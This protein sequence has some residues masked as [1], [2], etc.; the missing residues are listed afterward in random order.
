MN[1]LLVEQQRFLEMAEMAPLFFVN[2][3]FLVSFFVEGTC[4]ISRCSLLH[5]DLNCFSFTK[6]LEPLLLV[7][8]GLQRSKKQMVE[9]SVSLSSTDRLG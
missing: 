1:K 3:R 2:V 9:E 7:T 5:A 6:S 8:I 4:I